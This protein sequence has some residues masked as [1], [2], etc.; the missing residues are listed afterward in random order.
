[1]EVRFFQ[2]A[3]GFVRILFEESLEKGEVMLDYLIP[4]HPKMVH[5]PV[6]LFIT[7]FFFDVLSLLFR[8]EGLHKAAVRIYVFA[9]LMTPVVVRTGLWEEER[10]HLGHPLLEKH[11]VFALWTMWV[12]LM[13]LPVLWFIKQRSKKFFRTFFV[14][15]LI[16]VAVFVTLAAHNGG[17]LVYEYG[18]GVEK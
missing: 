9:A 1:M 10:L 7:A 13:S 8:K 16:T 4:I 11:R 3:P 2:G 18:T 14:I 5:F 12:S 6:A 15:L 17:R